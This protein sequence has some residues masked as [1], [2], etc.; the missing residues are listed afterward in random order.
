MVIEEIRVGVE[1]GQYRM[2]PGSSDHDGVKVVHVE[3]TGDR[4]AVRQSLARAAVS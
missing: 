1:V 4:H 3:G 2:S